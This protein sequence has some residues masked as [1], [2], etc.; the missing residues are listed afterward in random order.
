VISRMNRDYLRAVL[1][2][3]AEAEPLA[4]IPKS[5]PMRFYESEPAKPR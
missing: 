5:S 1:S 3:G 2:R 4:S